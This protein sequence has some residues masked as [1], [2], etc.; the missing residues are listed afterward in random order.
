MRS[1]RIITLLFAAA[2]ALALATCGREDPTRV[3]RPP[4]VRSFVP[5]E[6]EFD[7]FVGD[8]VLFEVIAIDPDNTTL[9]QRFTLNDSV[10]SDHYRWSYVVADTG[11]A[12]IVCVVTNGAYDSK[13]QW[14]VQRYKPV[15][16]PP[17]IT[18]YA[19]LENKPVIVIGNEVR[20]AVLATDPD[21]DPLW[22]RITVDDSLVA[23][24]AEYHFQASEV[25]KFEVRAEVSDGVHVTARSWDLTVTP[26]PDTN[27]PAEVVI[28]S[29]EKGDEPGDV[30]VE[31]IAVGADG[32]DGVASHYLVRTSPAPIDD[33]D[34]WNRASQ[35][36]GVP[37]PLAPGEQMSM[38]VAGL[39]PAQFTYVAVRAVDDFGNISPLGEAPGLYTR[40]MRIGGKVMDAL[41]GLPLPGVHVKIASYRSTTDS[42]GEFEL[43]ELPP[44]NDLLV[45]SDDNQLGVVGDYYDMRISYQVVHLDY[46]NVYLIPDYDLDTAQ[47]EDFYAFYVEMT[48]IGGS[49]FPNHQRR[50]EA[51][52]DIYGK[53]FEKGGLDYQATVHQTALDLNP[54][55]GMD[56][57]NVLDAPPE[58]GVVCVYRDN[59]VY[60]NFGV[61][62][63]SSDWY[64]VK[65][66]IEFRTV[67]SA[68]SSEAF[69][70]V[71]RHEL[72]HA[73]G[74]NHSTDMNHLMIGGVAPRVSNFSTDELAVIHVLY[75]IPRGTPIASYIRD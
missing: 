31:W 25:G 36:P 40:G 8:T 64:P 2:T 11:L 17:Q 15:N 35:R 46:R 67:Y 19:P 10:V 74:L 18:A 1:S 43:A 32:M 29:A 68:A 56:L 13:I 12:K 70:T 72:G 75:H 34:T 22:Y 54:Y 47:Y 37:E 6:H 4:V 57:F 65:A 51:P 20:F 21:G 26:I 14:E 27:P 52:I 59:V 41:T 7:A 71:I 23:T 73:L 49:P 69:K 53:P 50:W 28:T 24:E 44:I 9:K 58:V 16:W 61:L 42:N 33:E 60:D 62:L 3:D 63:W 5:P 66:D 55:I 45:F 48:E 30:R 39:T 38:V